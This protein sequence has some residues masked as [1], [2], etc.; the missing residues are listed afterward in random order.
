MDN[1]P[2]DIRK[3]L[4][5]ARRKAEKRSARRLF[6]EAGGQRVRVLRLWPTG[7]AVEAQAAGRLRG[8][9]EIFDSSRLLAR[10]LI[11]TSHQDGGECVYEFKRSTAP[12]RSA[13]LDFVRDGDAPSGY[14]APP[15]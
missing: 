2:E 10:C 11:V 12:N 7:F 8:L 13:P 5:A 4:V 6:V 1:L 15:S 9:V 14:L 3:G